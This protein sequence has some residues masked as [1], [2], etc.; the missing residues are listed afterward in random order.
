MLAKR[1]A[2]VYDE[3]QWNRVEDIL[4]EVLTEFRHALDEFILGGDQL[5]VLEVIHKI[6]LAVF[7]KEIKLYLTRARCPFEVVKRLR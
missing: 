7:A 4:V 5:M 2:Q 6:L 3:S 1:C